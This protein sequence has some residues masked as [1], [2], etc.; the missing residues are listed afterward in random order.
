MKPIP[1]RHK[2]DLVMNETVLDIG[3]GITSWLGVEGRLALRVVDITP[4]YSELDGT[5]K[6]VPNDIHHHDETLVG[7]TDPWLLF[8]VGAKCGVFVTA[9][10]FGFTLP[11]GK[12]QEDPYALGEQGL[13]HEHTQFGT[14]TL[15]PVVGGGVS[16]VHERVEVGLSGIAFFSLYE[17]GKGF[18]APNR[19]QAGL[20]TTVPLLE[21]VLRPFATFDLTYEGRELWHG[22][23]GLEGSF[24]QTSLLAGAG[25]AWRFSDPWSLEVSGRAVLARSSDA[26][27]FA[28][29]GVLGFAVSTHFGP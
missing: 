14:G 8:R 7:A 18:R 3:Y 27:T 2:V 26:P 5:P 1:Y 24:T 21:G 29:P 23:E 19:W 4:M 25:L 12:T 11:L 9:A 10:R 28:Y 13:S 15:V 6:S 17:N 22:K 20:R 16:Y